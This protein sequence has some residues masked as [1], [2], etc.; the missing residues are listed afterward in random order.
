MIEIAQGLAL[1]NKD[2]TGQKRK[3]ST[4]FRLEVLPFLRL[5]GAREVRVALMVTNSWTHD[6]H[7]WWW[8]S[9]QISDAR[10]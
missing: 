9:G 7:R 4:D 6:E 2:T 5:N 8:C 1:A 10:V 3:S